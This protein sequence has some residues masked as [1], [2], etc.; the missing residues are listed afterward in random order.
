MGFKDPEINFIDTNDI[1]LASDSFG[2]FLGL[3]VG[4]PHFSSDKFSGF[5]YFYP[6]CKGFSGFIHFSCQF[7]LFEH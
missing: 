6:F 3:E 5:G 7:Y 2:I 1:S 4:K